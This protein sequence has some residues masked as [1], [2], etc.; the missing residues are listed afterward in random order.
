MDEGRNMILL[1][2]TLIHFK[3]KAAK[4]KFNPKMHIFYSQRVVDIP[5]GLPKWSEANDKSDLIEDSPAK[6]IKDYKKKQKEDK[7]K[8]EKNVEV[9][10]MNEDEDEEEEEEEEEEAEDEFDDDEDMETEDDGET[11]IGSKGDK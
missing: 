11:N 3:T 8:E 5:D 9:E 7:E 4:K 2:P 10:N 6:A 1:F